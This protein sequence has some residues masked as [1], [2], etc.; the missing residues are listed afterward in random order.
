MNLYLYQPQSAFN[1]MNRE[2]FWLP[3]SMGS[4]WAYATQF[5]DIKENWTLKELGFKRDNITD[6]VDQMESPDLV[7]LN[8]Y[9]WNRNYCIALEKKGKKLLTNIIRVYQ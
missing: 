3:Y 5:E 2:V 1:Y 9:I 4:L 7:R 6:V 8:V